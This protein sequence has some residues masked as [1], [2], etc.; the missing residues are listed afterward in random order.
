MIQDPER[1]TDSSTS[2]TDRSVID[3]QIPDRTP[4]AS[5]ESALVRQT[6][7]TIE[8]VRACIVFLRYI[9]PTKESLAAG[10]TKAKP[11]LEL[12]ALLDLGKGVNGFAGTAHGGFFGVVLDEVMGS[13]VKAQSGVFPPSARCRFR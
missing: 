10:E 12:V 5:S 1:S 11:F 3:I 6:L 13:A 9:K 7:N 4:L 8:T 2:S